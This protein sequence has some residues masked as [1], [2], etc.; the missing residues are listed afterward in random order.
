MLVMALPAGGLF[1]WQGAIGGDIVGSLLGIGYAF[2]QLPRLFKNELSSN[3]PN[4]LESAPENGHFQLYLANL[5]V[6]PQSMLD[7]GWVSGTLGP[8][9]AGSYGVVMLIPQATQLLG[10]V[11]VQYIGPLVI[12]LVHINQSGTDRRSSI[13]FNAALLA[14]FS[15]AITVSALIAKR[16]PS[17]DHFFGKYEISDLSLVIVGILAC[18]QIYGLIEFHLIA[19]NRERDVLA[20]SLASCFIFIATF[21]IAGMFHASIEWFLAGAGAARWGQVWLLRRAYMRYA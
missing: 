10:N 9:L 21:A 6:A 8:M 4:T 2:W 16:I 15:L 3:T 20:A 18:G 1:G 14:I 11:I 12:K 13:E 19:H 17:L 7:R 5:A